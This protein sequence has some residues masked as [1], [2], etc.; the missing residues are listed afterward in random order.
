VWW[1]YDFINPLKHVVIDMM[2]GVD[3]TKQVPSIQNILEKSISS[4]TCKFFE[5]CLNY[6]SKKS[7][8][9]LQCVLNNNCVKA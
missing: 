6:T 8:A 5:K 9:Y 2:G 7:H 4:T 3:F 1:V